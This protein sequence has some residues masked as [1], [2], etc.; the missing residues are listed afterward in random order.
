MPN[1]HKW[2]HAKNHYCC[3]HACNRVCYPK[4]RL[5]PEPI[6]LELSLRRADAQRYRVELL[7]T[8]P[9][10]DA[11]V[12]PLGGQAL[13]LQ[14]DEA[15]LR[16]AWSAGAAVDY[17]Q[18]LGRMLC[19]EA[20]LAAALAA[21]RAAAASSGSSLRL[22]LTFAADAPELHALRWETLRLPG[23]TL[24]L[25]ISEQLLLTRTLVSADWQ[26]VTL[27]ARADLR[28]L[29]LIAAPNDL[30]TYQL[31]PIDA[32]AEAQRLL[33]ALG[34]IPTT[35]LSGPGQASLERMIS[36][37][38][39]GYDLLYLLAHGTIV[40][41]EPWLFLDDGQ[42]QTARVAGTEL[43][44]RLVDLPIRPRLIVLASCVS[45]G[46]GTSA[47]LA[48]LGPR[49]ATAGIPAVIAMQG[50]LSL[51]TNQ[52]LIPAFLQELQRDGRIDRALAAAR[53]QVAGR[54][55]WWVPLLFT[56]LRSG[57]IWYEPGF[58]DQDFAKWPTIAR[59]IA[60]GRCTPILGP[61]LL[62]ALIGSTRDLARRLAERHHFP[63]A[64][65][66]RDDLP[67]VAQYLAVHQDLD[68]LR[69]EL[70]RLFRER[71]VTSGEGPAADRSLDQLLSSAG[72]RRRAATADEPHRILAALPL[73]LYLTAN[74][75]QLLA[76][77]LR[78]AGKAPQSRICPWNRYGE[79]NEMEQ[80]P[81]APLS[82]QSPL[83]FQLFGRLDDPESLVL[84]EDDYFRYLIGVTRNEDLFPREVGSALVNTAL[85]FLGFRLEDWNFR[86][87]FQSV[88]NLAGA[89]LRRRHTHVAVQLDP[90]E[91]AFLD[92]RAAR[93]YLTTYFGPSSALQYQ[94]NISIYWGSAEDFLRELYPHVAREL[95]LPL[96]TPPPVGAIDVGETEVRINGIRLERR[97]P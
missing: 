2:P 35:Q 4:D 88:M 47:A 3:Y 7:L 31:A 64:P 49:L 27:R 37:L 74:P 24:P 38:R 32:P 63:L 82:V 73:P 23:D 34:T 50:E 16:E 76:D 11:P 69:D 28:A 40:A 6:D 84:T 72:A 15:A 96:P 8:Q 43:V 90:Q 62:E 77:A 19:A 53:Q 95:G 78:E 91:G 68:Y 87:L 10:S 85:L 13:F 55:D 67:Q 12:A 93:E 45:A 48:A 14:F 22:R 80:L 94:T 1:P 42:G 92:P 9:E 54:L 86:V 60:R 20:P 56:R 79:R 21:A 65:E 30:A 25:A 89:E 81:L 17:G 44:A 70:T 18:A 83:V 57:R 29:L 66:D 71:L 51:A 97:A 33:T 59:S 39:D 26:P 52:I 61:G 36:Q 75:D 46:D 5:M 58:D 41:G